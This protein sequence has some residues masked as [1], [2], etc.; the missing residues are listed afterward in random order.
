[1]NRTPFKM[2]FRCLLVNDPKPNTRAVIIATSQVPGIKDWMQAILALETG[3]I[4]QSMIRKI[5][6]DLSA[7]NL[8]TFVEAENEIA[9]PVLY[10]ADGTTP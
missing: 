9:R 1:M 10:S 4:V 6:F 7:A 2:R 5:D 3:A 8:V